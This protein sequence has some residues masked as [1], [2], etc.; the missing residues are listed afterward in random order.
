MGEQPWI[1]C[2]HPFNCIEWRVT[3]FSFF[4]EGSWCLGRTWTSIFKHHLTNTWGGPDT[5]R[6][7]WC[8]WNGCICLIIQLGADE[9]RSL[10]INS[11]HFYILVVRRRS[12]VCQVGTQHEQST[13]RGT[14]KTEMFGEPWETKQTRAG[15]LCSAIQGIRVESHLHSERRGQTV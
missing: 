7:I 12:R 11:W 4:G 13:E 5:V 6:G 15:G 10:L 1:C 3:L 9:T 8:E 2:R 14:S